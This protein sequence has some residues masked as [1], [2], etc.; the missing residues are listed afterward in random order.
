MQFGRYE[1]GADGEDETR[2][3]SMVQEREKDAVNRGCVDCGVMTREVRPW[4]LSG[5]PKSSCQQQF[6]LPS[7]ELRARRAVSAAPS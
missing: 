2:K 5:G 7:A 3:K 1:S 4:Q 6:Q